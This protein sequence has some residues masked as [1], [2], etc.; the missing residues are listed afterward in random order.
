MHVLIFILTAFTFNKIYNKRQDIKNI[1]FILIEHYSS[2]ISD[3]FETVILRKTSD[4]FVKIAN[5]SNAH[6]EDFESKMIYYKKGEKILLHYF[7]I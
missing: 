2:S 3:Q 1:I 4:T 6:K 5:T 7:K